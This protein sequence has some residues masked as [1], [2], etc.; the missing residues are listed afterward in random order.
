MVPIYFQRAQ[1]IICVFHLMLAESFNDVT[2]WI[3]LARNTAP[4]GVQ[5]LLIGNKSDLDHE[6]QINFTVAQQLSEQVGAKHCIETSALNGAGID[7]LKI[8][9]GA[10]VAAEADDQEVVDAFEPECTPQ[11]GRP[12]GCLARC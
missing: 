5:L 11:A 10:M 3:E 9:L 7:P 8:K 4:A 12:S 1:I 2:V 6:R